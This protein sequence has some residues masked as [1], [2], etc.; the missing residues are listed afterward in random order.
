MLHAPLCWPL[1]LRS[2][3]LFALSFFKKTFSFRNLD[4]IF[5]KK[6]IDELHPGTERSVKKKS[7][8]NFAAL[9]NAWNPLTIV[10]K[11]VLNQQ[12]VMTLL[13]KHFPNGGAPTCNETFSQVGCCSF[14]DESDLQ[15]CFKIIKKKSFVRRRNL[16]S[17]KMRR[18]SWFWREDRIG[19]IWKMIRKRLNQ[20]RKIRRK[21]AIKVPG[22]SSFLNPIKLRQR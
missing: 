15:R 21:K 10:S 2:H 13:T 9:C 1:T 12:F 20:K 17:E 22:K 6:T 5:R 3:L 14:D 7:Q 19:E 11:M 4:E 18:K 8:H 16:E